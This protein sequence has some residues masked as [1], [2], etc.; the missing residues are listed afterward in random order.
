L[1]YERKLQKGLK[2]NCEHAKVNRINPSCVDDNANCDSKLGK[3]A[4]SEVNTA[5]LSMLAR[6]KHLMDRVRKEN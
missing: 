5:Q 1:P 3:R 4:G 6:K 2:K